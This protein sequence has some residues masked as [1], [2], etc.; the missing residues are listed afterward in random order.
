MF[1]VIE[2]GTGLVAKVYSAETIR[3]SVH[4]LIYKDES[5]VWVDSKYFIPKS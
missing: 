3:G 4:F 2:K 1:E 5:W